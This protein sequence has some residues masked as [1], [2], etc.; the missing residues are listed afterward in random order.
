M[1]VCFRLLIGLN[2]SPKAISCLLQYSLCSWFSSS[3][4]H[5]A[6]SFRVISSPLQKDSQPLQWPVLPGSSKA[7]EM[8]CSHAGGVNIREN[9]EWVQ[10]LILAAV[11]QWLWRYVALPCS[12]PPVLAPSCCAACPSDIVSGACDSSQLF[13]VS[14]L[15]LY[16]FF[17]CLMYQSTA[18]TKEFLLSSCNILMFL[19]C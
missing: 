14:L 17:L 9:T 13:G 4:V 19:P 1:L 16:V 7:A 12:T 10:L 8:L 6:Q 11:L 2:W 15:G 3:P 18:V 5:T